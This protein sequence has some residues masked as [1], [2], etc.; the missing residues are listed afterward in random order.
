MR[1]ITL[2]IV[3]LSLLALPSASPAEVVDAGPGGFTSRN[4]ITVDAPAGQVFGSLVQDVGRWWSPA[5]TFS[6]DA[7]NLR[8][9][10][11]PQGCFCETLPDG[12]GVRHLT[13]VHVDPGR[14]L[15]LT[16]GLGPLQGQAVSGALSWSLE[17]AEGGDGATVVTVTY[18]VHGY[19]AGGLE[20]WAPGVDG[21]IR[22]QLERLG[23]FVETGDPEPAEDGSG[24]GGSGDGASDAG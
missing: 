3:A 4:S 16:G 22:Q 24:D 6:G 20:G 8:I 11:R 13:V 1:R 18:A 10:P 15:R 5:H 23:R 17:E 12:G 14:L 9:E 7:A 21:V 2:S 19:A